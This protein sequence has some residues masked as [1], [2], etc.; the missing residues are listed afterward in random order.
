[1]CYASLKLKVSGILFAP[2]RI[3]ILC[4]KSSSHSFPASCCPRAWVCGL[5]KQLSELLL[6]H[7]GYLAGGRNF[8]R[9]SESNFIATELKLFNALNSS[10]LHSQLSQWW[11]WVLD[12]KYDHN[13]F[14]F[15]YLGNP[16]SYQPNIGKTYQ[17][18]WLLKMTEICEIGEWSHTR[19]GNRAVEFRVSCHMS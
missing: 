14:K 1:M 13:F 15:P 6:H 12:F 19:W 16:E 9:R 11:C 10:N 18:N 8:F 2:S 5:M 4:R 17:S 3:F 7:S